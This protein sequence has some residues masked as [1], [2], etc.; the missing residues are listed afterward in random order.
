MKRYKTGS[1]PPRANYQECKRRGDEIVQLCKMQAHV[2]CST[3]QWVSIWYIML[4][5]TDVQLLQRG[6]KNSPQ[7]GT[8]SW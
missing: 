5:S 1:R 3:G 7:A 6:L 2:Q 4:Y 8:Y